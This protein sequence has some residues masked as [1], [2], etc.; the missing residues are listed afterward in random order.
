MLTEIPD[1]PDRVAV[2]EHDVHLG[3]PDRGGCAIASANAA[4]ASGPGGRGAAYS[5]VVSMRS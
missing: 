5:T 4:A 3:D 1:E 2:H